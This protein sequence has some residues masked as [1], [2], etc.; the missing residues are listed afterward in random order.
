[1]SRERILDAAIERIARDGIDGVRIARI[2]MD[3]G[4]STALVHYHFATREA[5][6]AEALEHSFERA[7]DVRTAAV[8]GKPEECPCPLPEALDQAC[9]NQELEVAG[10]ARL[11]LAQD[12]GEIGNGQFGLVQE[13]QD[14]QAR[15]LSG[16]LQRRVESIETE[17]VVAAHEAA[18]DA[19]MGLFPLYKDIFMPLKRR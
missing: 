12:V 10:D 13:G 8:L 1:V 18:R 11:R 7:G 4:V 15:F 14:P 19:F 2:A 6:L 17:P 5:L 3:A 9:F 16:R